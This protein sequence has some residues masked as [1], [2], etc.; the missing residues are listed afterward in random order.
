MLRHVILIAFGGGMGS[1]CRYY[2][3][4]LVARYLAHP[5]PLG[6]LLVNVLGCLLIGLFYAAAERG[7]IAS[8]ELRLLLTTGFC[9]GFT[10]FSTFSYET[11]TL[12]ENGQYGLVLLYV[13]GSVLLG[14]LATFAGVALVR[15]L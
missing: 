1:V 8:P 14:L 15:A 10:T 13:V 2:G 12:L 5:F 6:T 4:L 11:I 7:T 9:G 3:Q